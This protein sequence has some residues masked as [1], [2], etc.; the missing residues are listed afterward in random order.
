MNIQ[1]KKIIFLFLFNIILFGCSMSTEELEQEISRSISEQIAENSSVNSVFDEFIGN[2]E[3][4]DF[5]LIHKGGNEYVGVLEVL[6]P[7][8]LGNVFDVLTENDVFEDKIKNTYDVEVI[9]DGKTYS[10]KIISD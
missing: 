9:Y 5:Q 4:V 10:Y 2:I 6:E 1:L 3:F 8:L 7:N